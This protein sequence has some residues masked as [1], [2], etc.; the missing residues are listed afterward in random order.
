M[1]WGPEDRVRYDRFE[2]RK[3]LIGQVE[4]ITKKAGG[5]LFTKVLK[6]KRFKNQRGAAVL[7]VS[8]INVKIFEFLVLLG[9]RKGRKK[10][11][12]KKA[13]IGFL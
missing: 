9:V 11:K 1:A 2:S 7:G 13:Q 3:L 4:N 10:K 12:K 6:V 5:E 8:S